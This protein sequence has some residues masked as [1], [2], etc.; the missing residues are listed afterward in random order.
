MKKTLSLLSLL[1]IVFSCENEALEG[2]DLESNSDSPF[3]NNDVIGESGGEST[4]DYWPMVTGNKWTY[5]NYIDGQQED[6]GIM[7]ISLQEDYLGFPSYLYSSFLPSSTSTDGSV[8]G[9]VEINAYSSKNG[10]DYHIS[11]ASTSFEVSGVYQIS[12][13]SYSF[14]MLKDYL[15]VGETWTS[16][17]SITTSTEVLMDGLPDVPD[18]NMNVTYNNEIIE[19]GISV[20]VNGTTYSPV[21]KVKANSTYQVAG[22]PDSSAEYFYYF[23]EDVGLIKYEGSVYDG[24]DSIT[25]SIL[26]ELNEVILN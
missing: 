11:V 9:D 23:A 20:E 19:K 5:D 4:G 24:D 7:E 12:Q 18:T 26:A 16:N 22:L 25:T 3:E 17:Y 2:F 1:L 6:D 13:S 14:V 15:E 10:G 21:I 8:T